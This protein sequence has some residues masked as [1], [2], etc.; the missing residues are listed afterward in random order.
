MSDLT[1]QAHL[2][3]T[4]NGLVKNGSVVEYHQEINRQL[5]LVKDSTKTLGLS[6]IQYIQEVNS[7]TSLGH[8][9]ETPE[10]IR[11]S[12]LRVEVSRSILSCKYN[13]AL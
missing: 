4:T 10:Q 11:E 6:L 13:A 7:N 12:K 3:L 8:G 5:E 2:F 1:Q 9:N